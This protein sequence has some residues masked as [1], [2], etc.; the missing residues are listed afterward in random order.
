ME[1]VVISN[2][3]GN[4]PLYTFLYCPSTLNVKIKIKTITQNLWLPRTGVLTRILSHKKSQSTCPPSPAY[5]KK[6]KEIGCE[7]FEK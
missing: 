6:L 1:T 4:Y 2:G 5:I 7:E 3:V